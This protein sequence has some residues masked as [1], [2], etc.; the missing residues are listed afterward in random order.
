MWLFICIFFAAA[1]T[2][3]AAPEGR[4]EFDRS[5]DFFGR[6]PVNAAPPFTTIIFHDDEVRLSEACV[7]KVNLRD[8]FFPQL[9][10]PLTKQGVSAKQVGSF[11]MKHFKLSLSGTNDV[12]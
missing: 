11:L 5:A 6:M 3:A 4:W 2:W 1:N 7:A 9:F 12:Y 10:Q 8:Y